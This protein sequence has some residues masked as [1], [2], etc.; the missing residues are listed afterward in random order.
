M[1]PRRLSHI[2]LRC[3]R[4]RQSSD[5]TED[6]LDSS[7]GVCC[8][9]RLGHS[10]R[11]LGLLCAFSQPKPTRLSDFTPLENGL[12]R[13]V[14][15]KNGAK[16]ERASM[17]LEHFRSFRHSR[18]VSWKLLGRSPCQPLLPAVEPE[19]DH[20]SS[21]LASQP[22]NEET[23]HRP[24]PRSCHYKSTSPCTQGDRLSRSRSRSSRGPLSCKG[25]HCAHSSW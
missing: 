9:Y 2:W 3:S 7:Y 10:W 14:Q 8:A 15:D 5:G 16:Y 4:P 22:S 12:P 21:A 18:L 17:V 24:R 13:D 19:P 23:G 20:P 1:I 11:C 25:S 6:E